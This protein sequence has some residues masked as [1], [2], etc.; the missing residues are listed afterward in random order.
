MNALERFGPLAARVALA[1]IFL[2]SGL[3][4]LTNPAETGGYIA[5]K[6]LPGS[7]RWGASRCDGKSAV[8]SADVAKPA[9]SSCETTGM[10]CSVLAI[11]DGQLAGTIEP[12]PDRGP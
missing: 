5:S 11:R 1:A 9:R 3:M 12:G 4:K 2:I 8:T 6:G 7:T 10:T